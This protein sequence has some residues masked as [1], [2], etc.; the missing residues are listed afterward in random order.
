MKGR[1]FLHQTQQMVMVADSAATIYNHAYKGT[2][3]NERYNRPT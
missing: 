1:F 2:R 3:N